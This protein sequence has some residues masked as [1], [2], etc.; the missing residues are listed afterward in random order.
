[1]S[2][3]TGTDR[4]PASNQVE[5]LV[6]PVKVIVGQTGPTTASCSPALMHQRFDLLVVDFAYPF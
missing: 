3:V 2:P 5:S 6:K 4:F 1:M